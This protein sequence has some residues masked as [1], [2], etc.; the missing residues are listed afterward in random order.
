[1]ALPVP[2]IACLA[3]LLAIAGA[4]RTPA[5][6][7]SPG[8]EFDGTEHSGHLLCPRPGGAHSPFTS[9]L[10]PRNARAVANPDLGLGASLHKLCN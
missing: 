2:H 9:S 5:L 8:R 4:T 3:Q 6:G 1:M 10:I 7:Q